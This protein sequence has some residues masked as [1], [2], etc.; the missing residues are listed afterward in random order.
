MSHNVKNNLKKSASLLLLC[1][2]LI[3]ALSSCS[4]TP[5]DYELSEY[6][7]IP[8]GW[9]N[10]QVTESEIEERLAEEILRVRSNASIATEITE[11]AAL[12]GDMVNISM[13]CYRSAEYGNADASP[14]SEL[15]DPDCTF[16][17]GINKYPTELENTVIGHRA[18]ESFAVRLTLPGD[19]GLTELAYQTVVYEI[20]LNTLTELQ[21][22]LYNDAFVSS[23]SSCETVAE[24][25]EMLRGRV[26]E[27]IIWEKILASCE[28]KGYP[29]KE[30]NTY[31][32]NFI[33]YY[34]GLASE[35]G[36]TL[37]EYIR[38]K[39]FMELSAFQAEAVEYA[40]ENVKE[41]LLLYS[42][43]RAYGLELSDAEYSD[44][45]EI[46]V[47]EYDMRSVAAL[48]R[49]FGIAFVRKS[50]QLDKVLT[51][52]GEAVSTQTVGTE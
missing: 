7:T 14:I 31:E 21:L 50:V 52:I 41:D 51:F 17:I 24:Y 49:R 47:E 33:N 48:E 34:T 29:Q 43:V 18:T 20:T 16:I 1:V 3:G 26:R 32:H 13:V 39:F 4:S 22:P 9:Q 8:D 38:R 30:Y 36:Q 2:L 15:S 23:V 19:F 35:A 11:R 42:F 25:E 27:E 28:V 10:T 45:A 46:Y 12:A 40:Q 37:E 6:I 44:G 5:Y